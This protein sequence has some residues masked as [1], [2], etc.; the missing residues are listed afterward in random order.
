[1]TDV[2]PAS[3]LVPTIGRPRLLYGLLDSLA[4]CDPRPDE[5]VVVDQ[6]PNVATA[7]TVARFA[8]A[9]ARLI[10]GAPPGQARAM[11]LGLRA[12]SHEVVLFTDDDCTVAADWALRACEHLQ[13]DP[14]AIV[15]G[16]VTPC[17]DPLAVPSTKEEPLPRDY[18]G[19]MTFSA[20]YSGNM[21]I[22]RSEALA[23]GGFDERLATAHD[24]DFCYRWLGSGRALR[25]EPDM[26]VW[27]HAWRTTTELEALYVSYAR[28]QGA[29][30][31]KHL[32]RGDVM[33]L[34][35]VLRDLCDGVRALGAAAARRRRPGSDPRRGILRGL[36]GGFLEG[37][38]LPQ[39]IPGPRLP[40]GE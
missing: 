30:Y 2:V 26:I 40:M 38:R 7:R 28:G 19:E 32:R 5:I 8:G 24:N 39:R 25:Y 35:F 4:R 27:H 9:G 22:C 31:A 23:F 37:W 14:G 6:S 11:N 13:R 16:R 15:T 1:V 18:T 12:A 20:L 29:F 34:R 36:P 33:L 3:V 10:T 17:G 21:A